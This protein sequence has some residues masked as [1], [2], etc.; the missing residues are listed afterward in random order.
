MFLT[1]GSSHHGGV[2]NEH[3]VIDYLNSHPDCELSKALGGKLVH[4]GGTQNKADALVEVSGKT[5]SIKQHKGSG[6]FD[7][8]NTST[9]IPNIKNIKTCLG[10][11][12]NE[13]E[14]VEEARKHVSMVLSEVLFGEQ[15][16]DFIKSK[17]TTACEKN[18]DYIII[19]DAK[20][21][22]LVGF[23]NTSITHMFHEVDITPASSPNQTS[24]KINKYDI[25]V[26]FVLNNGVGALM[27][28]K[29]SVPCLKFQQDR[30]DNFIES[31]T[32]SK[33]L[34]SYE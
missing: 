30:V 18:C 7:W 11:I 34:V 4:K 8:I 16:V 24:A 19:N 9:D 33:I 6:T 17:L 32:E 27:K 14:D 26:R 2:T 1:D 25:R 21:K 23:P 20:N 28:N 12:K 31:I 10:V 29:N 22:R 5:V 15:F 3:F 13:I